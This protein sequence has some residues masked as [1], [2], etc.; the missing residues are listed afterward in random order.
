MFQSR[1][2]V[3]R[4]HAAAGYA[5]F[6]NQSAR[7]TRLMHGMS[8]IIVI[9]MLVSMTSTLVQVHSGPAWPPLTATGKEN[10]QRV[11]PLHK[12]VPDHHVDCHLMY[13]RSR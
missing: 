3:N 9:V 12:N 7:D 13:R 5:A 6:P 2:T 8:Y 4:H 10:N 11:G 1:D